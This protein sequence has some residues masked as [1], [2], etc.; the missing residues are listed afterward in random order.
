MPVFTS[1]TVSASPPVVLF[2]A[3]VQQSRLSRRFVQTI[4]LAN[5]ICLSLLR[6]FPLI[7]VGNASAA[8]CHTLLRLIF[9][10]ILLFRLGLPSES[11]LATLASNDV[12][13]RREL[14]DVNDIDNEILE[15][16]SFG[17][18]HFHGRRIS[19][20]TTT[21]LTE[22]KDIVIFILYSECTCPSQRTSLYEKNVAGFA[23]C[24]PYGYSKCIHAK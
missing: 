3:D 22:I 8:E 21:R 7:G 16:E 24:R 4:S 13:T 5:L 6:L 12:S 23:A 14:Y 20:L 10:P 11:Y 1:I 2:S 17:S 15:H 18:S 9:L 19:R